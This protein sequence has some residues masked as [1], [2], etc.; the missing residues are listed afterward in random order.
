MRSKQVNKH[1]T[2]ADVR[3]K[4]ANLT[5]KNASTT[6][7]F[8][9]AKTA[10]HVRAN[11][12]QSQK[13][14]KSSSKPT[15]SKT[16]SNVETHSAPLNNQNARL[17][18][19]ASSQAEENMH[20]KG[21][22]RNT[23]TQTEE[24][25]HKGLGGWSNL[26]KRKKAQVTDSI[27]KFSHGYK[28]IKAKDEE[29]LFSLNHTKMR[30]NA[31]K[32]AIF[33]EAIA[34]QELANALDNRPLQHAFIHTLHIFERV[35][36]D[37]GKIIITGMGK[38]SHVGRKIATT[39]ASTGTPAFFI[40]AGEAS[41]GDLG[42]IG[43]RDA[44]MAISNSGDTKELFDIID[45]CRMNHIPL[46]GM[47]R[48]AN[49]NLAK[50]ADVALVLP[51]IPEVCPLGKAPT[52]SATMC[53]VMGD[54]LTIVAAERHGFNLEKYKF[55][56]PGGKLGAS[57]ICVKDVCKNHSE[58]L[59]IV[60]NRE[61]LDDIIKAFKKKDQDNIIIAVVDK[62]GNLIGQVSTTR[63]IKVTTEEEN[64]EQFFAEEIMEKCVS[65]DM[66]QHIFEASKVLHSAGV[67]SCIVTK[68]NKPITTV[69]LND[70]LRTSNF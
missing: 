23:S 26:F 4:N 38:S 16:Q 2:E 61:L 28:V 64:A 3:A 21:M 48:M 70:L 66:E 40:H 7:Q 22:S 67:S 56:H 1:L 44:V 29:S 54:A 27:K 6:Q 17:N 24:S 50:K 49:S 45:Y 20:N 69:N 5:T 65:V 8:G 36:Q 10:T 68:N 18:K 42:S 15:G 35:K 11:K 43:R 41:H 46:I 52:T 25:V 55:W 57:M 19:D 31:A 58:Q 13:Y 32:A 63:I 34:I 47:T 30:I 60:T 37:D 51:N 39:L 9:D 12:A 33:Q 62:Q 14:T 59:L 53:M